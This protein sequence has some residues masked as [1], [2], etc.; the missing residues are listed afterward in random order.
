MERR[1]RWDYGLALSGKIII[2]PGGVVLLLRLRDFREEDQEDQENEA[3]VTTTTRA[4]E[5]TTN[6]P[7]FHR[8]KA[9]DVCFLRE[10]R[11]SVEES[12]LGKVLLQ[13]NTYES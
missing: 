4:R 3:K 10:L 11:K 6:R 12:T 7:R 8:F 13:K 5:L 1:R 2:F 9:F